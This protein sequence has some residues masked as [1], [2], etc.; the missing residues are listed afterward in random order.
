[1]KGKTLE[2]FILATGIWAVTI[3]GIMVYAS[4]RVSNIWISAMT[5][6]GMII[7]WFLVN[8]FITVHFLRK[9]LR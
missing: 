3:M 1:M 6:L 7:L 4:N 5:L 9:N 8:T 2:N